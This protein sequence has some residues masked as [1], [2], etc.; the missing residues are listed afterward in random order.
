LS[1]IFAI[2][3][4]LSA[5]KRVNACSLAEELEISSRTIKRDIERLR[6]THGAPIEWDA[7]SKTYYYSKPC[8]LLPLLRLSADEALALTLAGQ[9]FEA[10]A[11]SPLGRALSAA[12]D[13]IASTVGCAMSLPADA[14]SGVL[15]QP[16]S[17]P[18]SNNERRYFAVLLEAIRGKRE[19]LLEYRKPGDKRL[20]RRTIHPLHLA[21]LDHEW[22][23]VAFDL[24]HGELRN[25][26][27]SRI[28]GLNST[29]KQFVSP[30]GFDAHRYLA[31]S[32]GRFVGKLEIDVTV[33]FDAFS[34]PFIRERQWHPS[35]IL[36]ELPG[37]EVE[38]SLKV[39]HL[40]DVQR[41]V[42]SWGS[43][44]E[45]LAPIELRDSI[46]QEVSRLSSY[47]KSAL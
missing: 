16:E 37:N 3:D 6:D 19:M 27:L 39:N 46:A 36:R 45:A 30:A 9:T 7:S 47:Y 26:L 24:S 29:H 40:V 12:L 13:K 2:H 15:L 22:M 25:F 23:L 38:V 42:L 28:T 43:H 17:T 4:R 44:A 8:D 18:S 32:F 31:G 35:Q 41:W 34:A 20:S 5:G 11:G 33:R 1:R 14:L 21:Y 10:W